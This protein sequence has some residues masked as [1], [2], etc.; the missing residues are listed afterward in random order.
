MPI[1]PPTNDPRMRLLFIAPTPPPPS[2]PEILTQAILDTGHL[3]TA[4][5]LI[6]LRSNIHNSNSQKGRP[7]WRAILRWLSLW[8]K[9]LVYHVR[10]RPHATYTHL[11]Q[12]VSGFIRDASFIWQARCLGSQVILHFQGGNFRHF[13]RQQS[14]GM[15][16]FIRSTLRHASRLIVLSQRLEK[17]FDDLIDSNRIQAVWNGIHIPAVFYRPSTPTVTVLSLG[18]KSISKG[19]AIGVEAAHR[20]VDDFHSA[21]FIFAG[22]T[23]HL[24]KN[25]RVDEKGQEIPQGQLP[26]TS[27]HPHIQWKGPAYGSDK[28]RLFKDADIFILPSFSEG[29]P[30]VVLEAMS[31]SLPLIVTPV[32]ALPDVLKE[33]EN[34]LFVEPGSVDDLDKALRRLIESSELRLRMGQANRRLVESTL[35]ANQTARAL[36]AVIQN[37]QPL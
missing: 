19:T 15:Q 10:F 29:F 26:T 24:E 18:V 32:G 2:G 37:A 25:I 28:E 6:H 11:S 27:P 5:D 16:G 20:V 33:G 35:T 13:Y 8:M 31:Y 17:D 21:R 14:A 4:F 12:N 9:A 7:G 22:E 34:A 1:R 36:Q 30:M 3:Q 23:I